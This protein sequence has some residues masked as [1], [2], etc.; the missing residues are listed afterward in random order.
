[1]DLNANIAAARLK[2]AAIGRPFVWW[3]LRDKAIAEQR[4]R[5][6]VQLLVRSSLS[7]GEQCRLRSAFDRLEQYG[8][9][10]P[11]VDF[12]DH[13][14]AQITCDIEP[15]SVSEDRSDLILDRCEQLITEEKYLNYPG[16][17]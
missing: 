8:R 1:L 9:Q 15:A 2:L 14:V 3:S 7:A 17:D 13:L 4:G 11:V 5:G 6:C 10:C 12:G 16:N